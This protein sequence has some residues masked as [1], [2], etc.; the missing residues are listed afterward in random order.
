MDH[1]AMIKKCFKNAVGHVIKEVN[2]N[3]YSD[4]HYT[5]IIMPIK[6]LREITDAIIEEA[7]KEA[8]EDLSAWLKVI[9]WGLT[10]LNQTRCIVKIGDYLIERESNDSS[11]D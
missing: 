7:E 5:Y 2:Q 3:T 8:G 6:A 11:R 10:R 9:G 4:G 1:I